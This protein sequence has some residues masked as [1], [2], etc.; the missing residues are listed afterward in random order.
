[1]IT[2]MD[3][4]DNA[5]DWASESSGPALLDFRVLAEENVFPLVPPGASLSEMQHEQLEKALA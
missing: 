5:I 3:E 1:M 4:V 2:T